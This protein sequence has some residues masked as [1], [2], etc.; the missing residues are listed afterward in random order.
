MS[1]KMCKETLGRNGEDGEGT[2]WGA[3]RFKKQPLRVGGWGVVARNSRHLVVENRADTWKQ[4]AL[5]QSG[6][7]FRVLVLLCSC[8]CAPLCRCAQTLHLSGRRRNTGTR[9]L[10]LV[11]RAC[12]SLPWPLG[13][14]GSWDMVC[15]SLRRLRSMR[16]WRS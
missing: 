11:G 1:I 10:S 16:G 12:C 5:G 14:P 2:I 8:S 13:G 9:L 6:C 3:A 4:E 15:T 7:A